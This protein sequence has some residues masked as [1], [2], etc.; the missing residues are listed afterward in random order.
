MVVTGVLQLVP[1]R[2]AVWAGPPLTVTEKERVPSTRPAIVSV[3]APA[4][5]GV[6]VMV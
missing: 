6:T 3:L 5:D 4:L 2:V 1:V